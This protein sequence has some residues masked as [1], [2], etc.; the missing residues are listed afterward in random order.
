MSVSWVIDMVNI[1]SLAMSNLIDLT[2]PVEEDENFD[3]Y[4][5]EV[6]LKL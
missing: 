5:E 6:L 2:A 4:E 1:I 3:D